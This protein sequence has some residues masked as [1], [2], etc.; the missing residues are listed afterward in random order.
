M[1]WKLQLPCCVHIQ[2]HAEERPGAWNEIKEGDGLGGGEE[3]FK[4]TAMG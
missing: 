1:D 4:L 3:N 2:L